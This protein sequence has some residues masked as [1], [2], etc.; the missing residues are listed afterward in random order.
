MNEK[1]ACVGSNE[2]FALS[3]CF[4]SNRRLLVASWFTLKDIR[5]HDRSQLGSVLKALRYS[6][7][8]TSDQ[9]DEM[10][11]F[12]SASEYFSNEFFLL[13]RHKYQIHQKQN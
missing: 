8:F 11:N 13:H 2:W 6:K 7:Y 12:I 4:V 5:N 10:P 1:P 3:G 9:I